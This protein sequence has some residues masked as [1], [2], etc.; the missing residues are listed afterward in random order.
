MGSS[1][2]GWVAKYRGRTGIVK[3][4]DGRLSRERLNDKVQ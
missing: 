4:R 2:E 3:Y 1:V